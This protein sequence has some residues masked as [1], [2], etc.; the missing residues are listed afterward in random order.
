[1]VTIKDISKAC[2]Y[3]VST[4]SKALNNSPEI[5]ERTKELIRKT[6]SEMGY[7][8]NAAARL[9]KTNRS[10]NIGVLF[11]DEMQSGLR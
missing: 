1:M 3:S 2:G 11:V 9:L 5:G 10:N 4:V 7:L 8:P 6:A